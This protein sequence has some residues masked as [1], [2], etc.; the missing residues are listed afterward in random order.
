MTIT[1]EQL[2]GNWAEQYVASQLAS[3]GCLVRHVMQGHDSGIDLYC[4]KVKDGIAY[5]H[6][7]CQIKCSS[8]CK[9]KAKS[10]KFNGRKKHIE[11]W[12]KQPA[13]VFIFLVP[14]IRKKDSLPYYI[15]RSL[16]FLFKKKAINSIIMED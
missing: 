9:G 7:W 10:I 11:Y 8:K 15:C 1:D 4:E 2:K 3:C 14:D 13:P 5:L 12:V 6:F 16:D